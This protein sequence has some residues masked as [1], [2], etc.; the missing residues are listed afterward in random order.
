MAGNASISASAGSA[1]PRTSLRR[2]QNT[3]GVGSMPSPAPAPR[4]AEDFALHLDVDWAR[5][6]DQAPPHRLDASILF[7]PV[8]GHIPAALAVTAKG[9]TVVC[10]GIHMSDVPRSPTRCSG[11]NTSCA[12]SPISRE[13]TLRIFSRL[14]QKFQSAPIRRFPLPKPIG[15]AATPQG[16]ACRGCCAFNRLRQPRLPRGELTDRERVARSVWPLPEPTPLRLV[17]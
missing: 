7:A 1:R 11:A 8:G 10:G 12:R 2:S 13:N 5:G 9:G 6:S 14:R 16:R 15:A 3:R 4:R 17:R